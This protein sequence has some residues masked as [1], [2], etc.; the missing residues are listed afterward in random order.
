M[1]RSSYCESICWC[2]YLF[3]LDYLP[4]LNLE[5]LA[6]IFREGCEDDFLS[7]SQRRDFAALK[8]D[9]D[10]TKREALFREAVREQVEIEVYVPLRS[11][12]SKHLVNAWLNDDVEIKH[13]IK[14]CVLNRCSLFSLSFDV[15]HFLKFAWISILLA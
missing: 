7:I 2:E 8:D 1:C 9:C 10:N 4:I 12:I 3:L 13:K 5:M 15:F 11:T 14:V 6:I